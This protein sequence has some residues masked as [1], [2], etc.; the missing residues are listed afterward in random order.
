MCSRGSTALLLSLK[1]SSCPD[2]Q[3]GKK[4]RSI[5]QSLARLEEMGGVQSDSALVWSLHFSDQA[6]AMRTTL[7]C[8]LVSMQLFEGERC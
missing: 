6:E 1:R 8:I 7:T 2:A 3:E 5:L 4:Q